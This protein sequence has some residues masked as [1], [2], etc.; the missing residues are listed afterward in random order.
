MLE[1]V[2]Y[3]ALVLA[4]TNYAC[5]RA[6]GR[7]PLGDNVVKQ[8]TEGRQEQTE[9]IRKHQAAQGID[10]HK[11]AF[12]SSCADLCHW[13]Y[14]R[15]GIDLP[16]VN[17]EESKHVAGD[18][19]GWEV[20]LNIALLSTQNPLAHKCAPDTI[21]EPGDVLHIGTPGQNNDHVMIVRAHSPVTSTIEVAEY[22]Q[23]GGKI[24]KHT[25]M[26]AAS[27]VPG[28]WLMGNRRLLS[29]LRLTECL[30]AADA[31]GKLLPIALADIQLAESW[32]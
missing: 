30:T 25:L 24:N 11:W 18:G 3:P 14:F 10:P 5:N 32:K 9:L 23:P 31:A 8:V 27:A 13:L 2:D 15:F 29:Y 7:P 17:R 16:W 22:G 1:P 21:Y 19:V 26:S 20:E 28:G 4:L 6:R 12:Y